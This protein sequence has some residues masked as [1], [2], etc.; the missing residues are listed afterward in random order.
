MI[1]LP[2][3]QP[4]DHKLFLRSTLIMLNRDTSTC[5][6]E[7]SNSPSPIY[8]TMLCSVSWILTLYNLAVFDRHFSLFKKWYWK[9]H[10]INTARFSVVLGFCWKNSTS[11]SYDKKFISSWKYN[12]RGNI[13]TK[14]R[15]SRGSI[16]ATLMHSFRSTRFITMPVNGFTSPFKVISTISPISEILI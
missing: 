4:K 12:K 15:W 8:S 9:F 7:S 10:Q 11:R 16:T 5:S 13:F 2:L 6:S 14:L 1:A 3:H